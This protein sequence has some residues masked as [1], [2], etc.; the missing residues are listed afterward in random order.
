[1]RGI[2]QSNA[3]SKETNINFENKQKSN[4]EIIKLI[5]FGAARSYLDSQG[6]H[7]KQK[8]TKK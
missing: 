1:M 7:S 5:D 6:M 4:F 3:F 8:I 2:I